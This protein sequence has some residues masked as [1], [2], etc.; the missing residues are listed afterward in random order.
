MALGYIFKKEYI[1]ITI[2]LIWMF[3]YHLAYPLIAE[4]VMMINPSVLADPSTGLI[5]ADNIR[6]FTHFGD[7]F[8]F[9]YSYIIQGHKQK[10]N[11][12][13]I[14]YVKEFIFN[15]VCYLTCCFSLKRKRS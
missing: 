14:F 2:V 8:S 4:L 11:E 7:H 3:T 6:R 5:D 12:V 9:I 13:T 1:A 10:G 15:A